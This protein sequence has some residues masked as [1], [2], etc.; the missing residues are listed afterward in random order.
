MN[1]LTFRF[2]LATVLVTTSLVAAPAVFAQDQRVSATLVE[3][4]RKV[5]QLLQKVGPAVVA[6]TDDDGWGS[7]TIVSGDGLVLT[8]GHVTIKAESGW[9]TIVLPNGDRVRARVLGRNLKTDAGL[10]KLESNRYQGQPWPH[11]ELGSAAGLKRGDWTVSLGHPGGLIDA[12]ITAR[13]APVRMGRVLSIGGRTVVTDGTIIVGD[14]GG[15]LFNL[16]GQLIGVHSMIGSDITN[17][18]HVLVDVVRRDWA[19][20]EDG[21]TWGTL[22]EF[23]TGLVSSLLFGTELIWDDYEARVRRVV[24][25]SPAARAGIRSRDKLVSID[26]QAIADPLELSLVLGERQPGDQITTE[27]ERGNETLKVKVT[28]GP[29]PRQTK[30]SNIPVR[31]KPGRYEKAGE[32]ALAEFRPVV[33]R[34]PGVTVEFVETVAD[35]NGNTRELQ[36]ALGT[37][38]SADGYIATKYSEVDD[39]RNLVCRLDTGEELAAKVVAYEREFDIALVK[40]DSQRLKPV[41]WQEQPVE[42]GQI[43]VSPSRSG[44]PVASGVISVKTRRLADQ[45]FLGVQS[46]VQRI[47]RRRGARVDQLVP[48]GAAERA[49]LR[50]GDLIIQINRRV[51]SD[52]DDLKRRIETYKALDKIVVKVERPTGDR[53]AEIIDVEVILS[54]RFV[55]E[56]WRRNFDEEK[57]LLGPPLSAHA[58]G[59]P[60]ALQHDTVLRANQCGGPLLNIEGQAVGINISRA[61]RVMSYAIPASEAQKLVRTL[62]ANAEAAE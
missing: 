3:R 13:P 19:R 41:V 15:P 11:V 17:N 57:N 35:E 59:F 52:F 18:R 6:V 44:A 55:A 33:A 16:D 49:G 40:I 21:D 42:L 32:F 25:G 50:R 60:L 31:R 20:L 62:I 29:Y 9:V 39:A 22:G 23:D 1:N 4:E 46:N 2:F 43:V 7:G 48:D 45:G 51:I 58:T 34:S 54:A 30:E 36:L 8:A 56:Q 12:E 27:V 24:P 53:S 5:K 47:G 28:L 26:G 61:G 38:V 10:L 14:S 37:V